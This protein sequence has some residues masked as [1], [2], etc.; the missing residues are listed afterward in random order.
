MCETLENPENDEVEGCEIKCSETH[1]LKVD[2]RSPGSWECV[3]KDDALAP[4]CPGAFHTGKL[5]K[6]DSKSN[7]IQASS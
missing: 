7:I 1:I 2:P 6:Y 3:P 5:S 4:V